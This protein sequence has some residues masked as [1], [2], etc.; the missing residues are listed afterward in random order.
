MS[1]TL[2]TSSPRWIKDRKSSIFAKLESGWLIICF[3][4]QFCLHNL[5]KRPG[6]CQNTKLHPKKAGCRSRCRCSS[7]AATNKL[8]SSLLWV[9]NLIYILNRI[10]NK[11]SAWHVT[12]FGNC[13]DRKKKSNYFR[14]MCF[15]FGPCS[16]HI[17]WHIRLK[18]C[19]VFY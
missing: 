1:I 3:V 9:L 4:S 7:A 16:F 6:T 15:Y 11:I 19:L 8:L 13:I 18:F 17:E 2:I 10:P 12:L 14:N 5:E